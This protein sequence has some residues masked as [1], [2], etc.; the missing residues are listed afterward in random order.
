MLQAGLRNLRTA[1]WAIALASTGAL[2]S[3][4][5]SAELSDELLDKLKEKG[6]LTEEEYQE[7][8]QTRDDQVKMQRE[9]R[10][11]AALKEAQ[12]QQRE[13]ETKEAQSKVAKFETGP[14]LKSIQFYGDIRLRYESRV[15][16][17]NIPSA[18][19]GL[20]DN[21]SD[22][23]RERW[24]YALRIGIRGDLADDWFYGLRLDTSTNPRSAWVTFGGERFSTASGAGPSGKGDDGMGVGQ[25]FLGW[26][27]KPWLTLQAGKMPNPFYTTPMMWDPDISPE[28]IAERFNYKVSDSLEVFGNFAQ[29]IYQDV[30][31]DQGSGATLGF[32]S[33]DAYM[34]GW[35][36][37]ATYK[38]NASTGLKAALGYYNYVGMAG[39]APFIGDGPPGTS[40]TYFASQNGINN[41]RILEIPF[42]VNFMLA[43]RSA[44]VFGD[45]AHNLDADA[46][47]RAAGHSQHAGDDSA[48]QLG[49]AYGTLGTVYGATAKKGTWEV[50]TYWQRVEQ[51]ALDPNL[52]DSDFFEGRTNLQGLYAAFAY[53]FSDNV[54][55]TLRYGYARRI[56]DQLG[57]GGSN[58]DLPYLNPITGYQLGQVDLTMRF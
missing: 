43:D 18:G 34:L 53:C 55:G 41:L 2:Y 28:G 25:V 9:D 27:A 31:P 21:P 12:R 38:F 47:A 40:T 45:I 36:G 44:R 30:N 16:E 19:T 7:L 57:T 32:H 49:F 15:G 50:R 23:S 10:R 54:I 11:R 3:A 56:N 14:G 8:K 5:A 58:G 20:A 52:T 35:Q 37:G 22:L 42:E 4:A 1:V 17:S 24:R 48:Y 26:R 39:S 46:R 13:E 33:K 6:I 51:F 29:M